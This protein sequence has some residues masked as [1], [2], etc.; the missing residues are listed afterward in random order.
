MPKRSSVL[1]DCF[2]LDCAAPQRRLP[3]ER[4]RDDLGTA[5]PAPRSIPGHLV[6]LHQRDPLHGWRRGRV[7]LRNRR[8]QCRGAAP[9][10]KQ[11]GLIVDDTAG[12]HPSIKRADASFDRQSPAC[13]ALSMICIALVPHRASRWTQLP[14]TG[15]REI[16]MGPTPFLRQWPCGRMTGVPRGIRTCFPGV[17]R[18]AALQ[19]GP[20]SRGRRSPVR[21]SERAWA[22][23]WCLV[24]PRLAPSARSQGT[25]G[26][27]KHRHCWSFAR[28]TVAHHG[29]RTGYRAYKVLQ[30]P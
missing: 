22:W 5:R 17:P 26:E 4:W 15:R 8:F 1:L 16:R 11:W 13:R 25:Y 12:A 2:D 14:P 30:V 3:F 19:G 27:Q 10:Y 28:L 24:L 18:R 29:R 21:R 23:R 6:L 20:T 9:E 7:G